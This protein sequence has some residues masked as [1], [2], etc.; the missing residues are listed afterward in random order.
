MPELSHHC[1]MAGTFF[2]YIYYYGECDLYAKIMLLYRICKN[3]C[4]NP[5]SAGRPGG[6]VVLSSNTADVCLSLM[7][8]IPTTMRF[9]FICFFCSSLFRGSTAKKA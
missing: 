2:F 9:D 5:L 8:S 1:A 4:F 3:F 6:L 7:G